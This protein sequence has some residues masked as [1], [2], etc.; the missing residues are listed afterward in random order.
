MKTKR[1]V[2][3]L[4]DC[5]HFM[6]QASLQWAPY[7]GIGLQHSPCLPE[8]CTAVQTCAY[9][10][11]HGQL[12]LG[13]GSGGLGRVTEASLTGAVKVAGA[14]TR[15]GKRLELQMTIETQAGLGRGTREQAL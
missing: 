4:R 5:K 13:G 11:N 1:C 3:E 12:P 14:I 10:R 8:S 6:V 9:C 2:C 15:E 7:L